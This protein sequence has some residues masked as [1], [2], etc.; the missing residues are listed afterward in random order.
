MSLGRGRPPSNESLAKWIAELSP[1]KV[2]WVQEVFAR[3]PVYKDTA[4]ITGVRESVVRAIVNGYG[5]VPP[6]ELVDLQAVREQAEAERQLAIQ[7]RIESYGSEMQYSEIVVEEMKKAQVAALM[8]LQNPS[9]LRRASV[10]ELANVVQTLQNLQIQLL[11]LQVTNP[12]SRLVHVDP[13]LAFTE[14]ELQ[15]MAHL[16][17][18]FEASMTHEVQA[19][20]VS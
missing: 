6:L 13:E 10:M 5:E 17:R 12:N 8:E 7:E 11:G 4:Q 1:E 9:K 18:K 19:Y 16:N 15:I 20:E 2:R 14:E 3:T